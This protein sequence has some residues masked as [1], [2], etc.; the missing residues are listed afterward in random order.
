MGLPKCVTGRPMWCRTEPNEGPHLDPPD[1]TRWHTLCPHVSLSSHT[2]TYQHRHHTQKIYSPGGSIHSP[3]AYT[4]SRASLAVTSYSSLSRPLPFLVLSLPRPPSPRR[5][6]Y[7]CLSRIRNTHTYLSRPRQMHQLHI[8]T[9]Y[10]TYPIDLKS[11]LFTFISHT[12]FLLNKVWP[13]NYFRVSTYIQHYKVIWRS[14]NANL[15]CMVPTMIFIPH[16]EFVYFYT[17]Y[18]VSHN[19]EKRRASLSPSHTPLYAPFTYAHKTISRSSKSKPPENSRMFHLSLAIYAMTI[20]VFEAKARY[21]HWTSE[22][23]HYGH[24]LRLV[25]IIQSRAHRT[26]LYLLMTW[27]VDQLNAPRG[28][29]SVASHYLTTIVPTCRLVSTLHLHSYKIHKIHSYKKQSWWWWCACH[30]AI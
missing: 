3:L 18:K 1:L 13:K 8:H 15:H 16:C 30:P 4:H 10:I 21:I 9:C 24:H 5:P 17:I 6:L 26:T 27:L 12:T 22:S 11:P 29:S 2:H 23:T 14:T 7:P 28:T 19:K 20:I 25:V